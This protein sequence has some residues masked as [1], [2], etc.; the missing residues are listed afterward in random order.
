MA[1]RGMAVFTHQGTD[2]TINDPNIANE[3]SATKNYAVG[4]F[5]YYQGDLY[6]FIVAHSAGAWNGDHVEKKLLYAAL[7]ELRQEIEAVDTDIREGQDIDMASLNI[8]NLYDYEDRAV[9]KIINSN[10]TIS[11]SVGFDVSGYIPVRPGRLYKAAIWS[12]TSKTWYTPSIGR[13]NYYNKSKT[14]IETQSSVLHDGSSLAPSGAAYARF[15]IDNTRTAYADYPNQYRYGV[16]SETQFFPIRFEEFGAVASVPFIS[17]QT[18]NLFYFTNRTPNTVNGITYEFLDPSTI[19]VSGTSTAQVSFDIS[20]PT[21]PAGTYAIKRWLIEDREVNGVHLS[22]DGVNSENGIY[23]VTATSAIKVTVGSNKTV[24]Q[25]ARWMVV[26]GSGSIDEY[27]SGGHTAVDSVAREMI[28]NIDLTGDTEAGKEA[29]DNVFSTVLALNNNQNTANVCFITDTHDTDDVMT[30]YISCF[31]TLNRMGCMDMFV[32][33]GD[34]V[35]N[36]ETTPKADAEDQLTAAKG[37]LKKLTMPYIGLL[38]N[39][40][41]NIRQ[42]TST[43][44]WIK[45]SEL[46]FQFFNPMNRIRQ[47]AL[48]NGYYDIERAKIRVICLNTSDLPVGSDGN[49]SVQPL[50]TF[51]YSQEQ[52]DWLAN[53]ALNTPDGYSVAFFSHA[54]PSYAAAEAIDKAATYGACDGD[55][56]WEMLTARIGKTTYT[57]TGSRTYSIMQRDEQSIVYYTDYTMQFSCDYDFSN[58]G[59]IEYIGWF[60][61]HTHQDAL[62]ELDLMHVIT[63]AISGTKSSKSAT[64]ETTSGDIITINTQE[65]TVN[66][67]RLGVGSNRSYSYGGE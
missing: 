27:V 19:K 66:M 8:A 31:N 4:D 28:K 65:K 24:D 11:T 53:E 54:L 9:D 6:R 15:T 36:K 5:C 18:E 48:M 37:I 14:L 32:H 57:E 62:A 1:T 43:V 61:G 26:A 58:Y 10:G 25:I 20:I 64:I 21:L 33:G 30:D 35:N 7:R 2:Y 16:F 42:Y 49:Y 51:M 60:C 45:R 13:V 50:S 39:H 59:G 46:C 12:P 55:V 38:G 40:D 22:I 56:L 23:T 47:G 17:E 44:N 63:T 3:F 29:A 67:T 52:L 34:F 41:S